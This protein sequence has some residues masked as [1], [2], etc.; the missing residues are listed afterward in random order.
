MF[1]VIKDKEYL[2]QAEYTIRNGELQSCSGYS[3][4][5]YLGYNNESNL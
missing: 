4:Q 1:N 3:L 2:R 5:Y